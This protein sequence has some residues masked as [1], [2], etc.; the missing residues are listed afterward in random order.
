M[1]IL[2]KFQKDYAD[3][4]DVYG[5][6][7]ITEEKWEQYKQVF[8]HTEY[9]QEY[10]FGTNEFVEFENEKDV[11]DNVVVIEITESQ[12]ELLRQLFGK[13]HSKRIDFGFVPFSYMD[14]R[15]PDAVY[16]QIFGKDEDDK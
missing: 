8:K 5:F 14:E 12:A 4:F 15:L 7:V 3:E 9:P 13:T 2:L 1:P 6:E 16:E 11:L 10:Y